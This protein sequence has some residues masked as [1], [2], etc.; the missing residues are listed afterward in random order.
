MLLVESR[1]T[2]SLN[3]RPALLSARKRR[4]T[5]TDEPKV[6][7]TRCLHGQQVSGKHHERL[8]ALSSPGKGLTAFSV[9]THTASAIRRTCFFQKAQQPAQ[10]RPAQ[11]G[12]TFRGRVEA[13][14]LQSTDRE[15]LPL[16]APP[17]RRCTTSDGSPRPEPFR[18]DNHWLPHTEDP[19]DPLAPSCRR[20]C[21]SSGSMK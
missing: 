20:H 13:G 5:G 8:R 9:S 7:R 19:L 10:R 16:P 6:H 11:P 14:R 18:Q 1:L 15:P 2:D 3:R 12:S 17:C 4:L 21:T